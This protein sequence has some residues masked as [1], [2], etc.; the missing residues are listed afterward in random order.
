ME[1]LFVGLPFPPLEGELDEDKGL[2]CFVCCWVPSVHSAWHTGA[3]ETLN[4]FD[5]LLKF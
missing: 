1:Y 3:K 2:I 4:T 5:K